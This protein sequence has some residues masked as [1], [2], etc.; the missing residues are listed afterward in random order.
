MAVVSWPYIIR[1][2]RV[3]VS[4][5]IGDVILDRLRVE[6]V[7]VWPRLARVVCIK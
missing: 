6:D 7:I 5:S 1:D 2:D 3:N 4:T